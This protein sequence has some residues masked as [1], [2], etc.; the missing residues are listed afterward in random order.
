MFTDG[1]QIRRFH[2]L[3]RLFLR[4]WSAFTRHFRQQTSAFARVRVDPFLPVILTGVVAA[5]YAFAF[6]LNAPPEVVLGVLAIGC[7]TAFLET[8]WRN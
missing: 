7:A 2:A 6:I 4:A 3:G 8:S 5:A 1:R